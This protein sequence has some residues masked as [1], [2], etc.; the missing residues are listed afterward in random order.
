MKTRID[1]PAILSTLLPMLAVL[2][3]VIVLSGCSPK[4]G[5]GI[6]AACGQWDVI[7]ASRMDTLDTVGQIYT[8]NVK[9]EAFCR[10]V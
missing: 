9:R 8:N 3:L 7:Y 10:G 5:S 4:A 6:E 2:A 1:V